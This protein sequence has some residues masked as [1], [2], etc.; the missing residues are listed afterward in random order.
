[1]R[2]ASALA[3]VLALLLALAVLS[4]FA[5]PKPSGGAV[6]SP[7]AGEITP[8]ESGVYA[9]NPFD[10]SETEGPRPVAA[11]ETTEHTFERMAAGETGTHAFEIEN[12]GEAPLKIAMGPSSC[13]CTIGNLADDELPP[14]EST[15]VTLEWTPKGAEPMFTQQARIWTNDP[16]RPEVVL[17]VSGEVVNSVLTMPQG[18]WSLG[19][20]PDNE[21]TEFSGIIASMIEDSFEITSIETSRPEILSANAVPMSEE[22]LSEAGAVSGYRLDCELQPKMPVGSFQ[23]MITV[24][25]TLEDNAEFQFVVSGQRV[26]PFNLVGP[27]WTQAD[28]TL[29]MGRFSAAEGKTVQLSLFT[30]GLAD[31]FTIEGVT[32]EPPVL[33]VSTSVDEEFAAKSS[34][35]SRYQLLIEA[36]PGI[37]PGRWSGD[38]VISVE[39]QTNHSEFSTLSFNIDM[40][41]D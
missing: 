14:G 34:G 37:V 11:I 41:A 36:P 15:E 3:G 6:E 39:L 9:V 26:G 28:R 7:N 32:V 12:T 25:T 20:I 19:S 29:R 5:A 31:D 13:T 38:S 24:A 18:I 2:F 22:E 8:D 10:F 33:E 21:P 16:A 23:E 27:G 1:M 17:S 4:W 35:R 30:R 40:Q